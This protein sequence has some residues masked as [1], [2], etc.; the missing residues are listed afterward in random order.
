MD[1]SDG[2]TADLKK[3]CLASDVAAELKLSSIPTD[4]SLGTVFGESFR[5]H[6]IGGGEDFELL[7]TAPP[8]VMNKVKAWLSTN[9]PARC[10]VI[11]TIVPGPGGAVFLRDVDGRVVSG[12]YEGFD[13]F[14]T[15]SAPSSGG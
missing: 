2:L 12:S 8:A 13:H 9:S 1:V 14:G 7:F 4:A 3:L 10:T 11:G 15:A 6:A 5:E